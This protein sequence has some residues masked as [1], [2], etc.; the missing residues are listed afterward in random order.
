MKTFKDLATTHKDFLI[1]QCEIWI[2]K[3]GS[4]L[5]GLS[6]LSKEDYP[7][8][9]VVVNQS[10]GPA[11]S[12]EVVFICP[13]DYEKSDFKKNIF[14]ELETGKMIDIK[15]GYAIPETVFVGVLGSINLN[16][17]PSGITV[18][19]TCYDVKMTLFYNIKWHS[20]ASEKTMKAVV[21]KILEPCMKYGKVEVS[22]LAFDKAVVSGHEVPWK[23]DNVDDY[24]FLAKLASLTN[25]SFYVSKDTV[26]FV[27]SIVESTKA[28]VQLGW[29]KGLMSFSADVDISGQ[30]GS[31]EIAFRNAMRETDSVV[32]TGTKIQGKGDRPNAGVVEDK[33]QESTETLVKNTKQAQLV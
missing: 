3:P 8:L 22:S 23:Q 30:I 27:D 18:G 12:A 19:V 13:Y 6:K 1:P 9:S 15:L 5:S 4:G 28:E 10:V 26:Y 20:Y 32:V 14:A 24:R 17:T 21:E 29:G 16:Y 25:A 11:S 2:G 7:V 33:V 31:V